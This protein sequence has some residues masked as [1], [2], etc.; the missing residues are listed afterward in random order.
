MVSCHSRAL[1]KGLC[2]VIPPTMQ[3]HSF[4]R[5]LPLYSKY[6]F[7][8]LNATSLIFEN[9][10]DSQN[11]GLYVWL[12]PET[13]FSLMM[14]RNQLLNTKQGIVRYSFSRAMMTSVEF[15]CKFKEAVYVNCQLS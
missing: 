13:R 11:D 6:K 5:N 9:P 10:F 1:K 2:G 15:K 8:H 12:I 7:L 3:Q 14:R 4:F